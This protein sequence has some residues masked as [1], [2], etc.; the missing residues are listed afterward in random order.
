M[1]TSPQPGD[2]V[3]YV[4]GAEGQGAGVRVA[5]AIRKGEGGVRRFIDELLTTLEMAERGQG[6][7]VERTGKYD[8]QDMTLTCY[9]W[10]LTQDSGPGMTL[11]AE[12]A[13][14]LRRLRGEGPQPCP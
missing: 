7:Y 1:C 8:P 13:E 9:L 11:T 12:G 3:R 5:V 10:G 14:V 2:A 4:A 6:K